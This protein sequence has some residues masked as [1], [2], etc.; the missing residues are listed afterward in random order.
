M[1]GT[2]NSGDSRNR[3]DKKI[4]QKLVVAAFEVRV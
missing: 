3:R 1:Y 2:E 4:N